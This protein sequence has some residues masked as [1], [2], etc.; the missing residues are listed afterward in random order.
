MARNTQERE[1]DTIFH[2]RPDLLSKQGYRGFTLN[3][4]KKHWDGVK[5]TAVN[6][7]GMRITASGETQK[8]SIKKLIDQIDLFLD[9]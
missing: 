4:S 6:G 2:E 9:Q 1:R 7:K 8:E 3:S 5:I